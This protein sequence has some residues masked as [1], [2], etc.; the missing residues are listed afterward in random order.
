VLAGYGVLSGNFEGGFEWLLAAHAKH[1]PCEISIRLL[2]VV[3]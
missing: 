3:F 2:P 1:P